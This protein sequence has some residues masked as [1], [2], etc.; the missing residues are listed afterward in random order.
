MT[1][2]RPIYIPSL[3]PPENFAGPAI[4]FAFIGGKMAVIRGEQEGVLPMAESPE[5]LGLVVETRHYL[6]TYNGQHCFAAELAA[7]AQLPGLVAMEG[8]RNL[9]GIIEEP[10]AVLAG[11][12][13]QIKEWDRN[14][15]FCGRC[16]Q[17]TEIRSDERARVC[18][19][20]R[21][22][23]YP[24]VAPAVMVLVLKGR[25][26]LLA[27]RVGADA[28]RF[29]A[30]AGFVEP[31][32]EL[33]DTAKREVREEVGIEIDNIRY[34]GSQ[35]WPFPHSLMVAFTAHYAGGPVTPD[36]VEIEEARWFAADALPNRPIT[37]SIGRRLVDTIAARL[38]RGES[39]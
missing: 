29:S 3:T 37:I 23:V 15:R 26:L 13:F 31:G 16:G 24:P 12:A 39:V 30:L 36:G 10:M 35:P 27:R 38:A 33:E 2:S 14:Y 8:L 9:F 20:C 25:E 34:F 1:Q 4:W 28:N 11:R 19:P 7:G 32:E 22:S 21:L 18:R 5:E 6:G 17:P